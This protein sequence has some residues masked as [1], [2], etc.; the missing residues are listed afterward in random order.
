MAFKYTT[1][2]ASYCAEAGIAVPPAFLRHPA[3][4]YAVI[5]VLSDGPH[6]VARTWFKHEDVI[7]YL[8][9]QERT[10]EPGITLPAFRIL[11]FKERVELYRAGM[12]LKRG[13]SF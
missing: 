5:K 13:G 4:R 10:A 8:G 6:L 3:S 9:M 1:I 11:D 2:I 12:Q 7:Y